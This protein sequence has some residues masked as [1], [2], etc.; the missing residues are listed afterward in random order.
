MCQQWEFCELKTGE[1]REIKVKGPRC[2]EKAW[3]CNCTIS[4]YSP[5]MPDGMIIHWLAKNDQPLPYKSPMPK[6][7]ALL[8]TVGWD[9]VS[10][11]PH[12]SYSDTLW[13]ENLPE[14]YRR[15]VIIRAF[16]KRPIIDGQPV[17]EPKIVL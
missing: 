9:L 7:M 3:G 2:S 13:L 4:Y 10:I 17:D 16:F 11:H 1:W 6:A 5:T 14:N 15:S 12:S 8:G